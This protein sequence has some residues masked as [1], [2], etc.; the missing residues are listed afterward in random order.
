MRT[1]NYKEKDYEDIFLEM[2]QDAYQYKLVSTD[3]RFLDY[4]QNRQDIENNYCLFLSVYAF[5]HDKIYEDMTLIY[6]SND[7]DKAKGKDLDILGNK[8]GIPRPQAR[9]SSVKL[10]FEVDEATT[11]DSDFI[12]PSKTIVSTPNGQNYYTVEQATI[13]RGRTSIEVTAYSSYTG[14]NSRVD[15]NTLTICTLGGVKKV[16]NR[17]GSSGGRGAY[18]DEEYRRLIKNWTYSHIKGTKEAYEL[19]FSYYDGIDDYRLV[20]LWDGAGTVKII[21]DPDDD[22]IINDVQ[23]KLLENVQLFDDDVLVTGALHRSIDVD[24]TINV[25][26]DNARYYSYDERDIIAERVANA[27]QTYIDGGYRSNGRYYKGMGIGQDFVPYQVGV[28][29]HEELGEAVKSVDFR[30]TIKNIDETIY[31]SELSCTNIN[32]EE[33]T[34]NRCYDK[35]SGILYSDNKHIFTSPLLYVAN[36]TRLVSDNKGFTISVERNGEVLA[37]TK[38]STLDLEGMDLYG[39]VIKLKNDRTDVDASISQITITGTNSIND[40]NKNSYNA[41]IRLTDEEIATMGNIN[42]T[43]QDDYVNDSYTVCY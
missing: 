20:P 34:C 33:K 26:I 39:A 1:V 23:T 12:I 25:D 28:F 13:I 40:N 42:V 43:V 31:A 9:R 21:V 15:R 7:L 18:N 3:E 32:E 24:V 30:D 14:Y 27:I 37:S 16:Y 8:F 36:A 17:K 2:M 5:E 6:N 10:T 35:A 11:R 29:I 4:I 22:W 41:H 19:F 38:D